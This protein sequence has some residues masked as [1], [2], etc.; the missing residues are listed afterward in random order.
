MLLSFVSW[1]VLTGDRIPEPTPI[2]TF[3]PL[4]FLDG[5]TSESGFESF[6]RVSS[7]TESML[8]GKQGVITLLKSIDVR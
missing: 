7:T 8:F 4:M 1:I 5:F 2:D 6:T 3:I